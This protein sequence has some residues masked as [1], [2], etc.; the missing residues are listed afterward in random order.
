VRL[1]LQPLQLDFDLAYLN[2]D[3]KEEIY[4]RPPPGFEESD[5]KLWRLGYTD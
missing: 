2:A 4:M 1:G 3:L 5:G